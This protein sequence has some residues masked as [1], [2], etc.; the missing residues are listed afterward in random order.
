MKMQC[1]PQQ[2]HP[3]RP[4]STHITH[5]INNGNQP[6][7]ILVAA[8]NSPHLLTGRHLASCLYVSGVYLGTC[9]RQTEHKK[10]FTEKNTVKK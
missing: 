2:R 8:I 5:L 4:H 1:V 7:M 6:E 3:I 10:L 9:C